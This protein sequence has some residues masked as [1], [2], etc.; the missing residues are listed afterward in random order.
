MVRR[1]DL[2]EDERELWDHVTRDVRKPRARKVAPPRKAVPETKPVARKKTVAEPVRIT[3]A[4]A[5]PPAKRPAPAFGV[6]GA[7]AERL[8][9]GKIEPE[10][11][12]DL[13]GLTQAQ[14]YTRLVTFVRRGHEMGN[15]CLLV[16]TGKGA[17]LRELLPRW[18]EELR[19]AVTGVQSAHVR[20]GGGGA[21]Y[22]YL[23]R[24]RAPQ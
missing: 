17:V 22:V 16:I 20:H 6:D 1:R 15:R 24:K 7:T 3:V 14:A 18:L 9:R 4:A 13:H 2:R 21:F 23:R 11:V 10:A 19:A 12:L 5:P 8:R